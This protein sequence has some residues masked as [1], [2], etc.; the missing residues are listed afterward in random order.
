MIQF[1][2]RVDICN[3]GTMKITITEESRTELNRLNFDILSS[4][5]RILKYIP[6]K[7]AIGISHILIVDLPS[8]KNNNRSEAKASYIP[9]DRAKLAHI[10][11]YLKNLFSHIKSSESFELMLPIQ[12]F[13]LAQAVF[14]EIGHHVRASRTHGIKRKRSEKF[15]FAYA[16]EREI[17]YII[18]CAEAINSCFENLENMAGEKDLNIDVINNMRTGWRRSHENA[19]AQKEIG[20]SIES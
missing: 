15:A 11:I 6:N 17:D 13:G 7:D 8:S 3:V 2:I 18:D 20:R 5:H 1:L 12:E 10:E 4:I 16:D 19:I 9:K 14:H